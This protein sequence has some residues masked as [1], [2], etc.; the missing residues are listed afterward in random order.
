MVFDDSF[1]RPLVLENYFVVSLSISLSLFLCPLH[2]LT[3]CSL[4][5]VNLMPDSASKA[6]TP[7]FFFYLPP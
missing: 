6:S 3:H 2:S 5:G 1:S 7:T 4:Y